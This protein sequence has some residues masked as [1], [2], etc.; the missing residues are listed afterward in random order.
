MS[1]YYNEIACLLKV[2]SRI[3]NAE[4]VKEI[5]NDTPRKNYLKR[6]ISSLM[7]ENNSQKKK[8][9]ILNQQLRRQKKQISSLKS[10]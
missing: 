1:I 7:Q 6:T 8:I 3:L 9:K 2:N 10:I 4:I 5:N